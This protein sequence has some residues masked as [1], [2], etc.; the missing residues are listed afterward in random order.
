[1]D[2]K[3]VDLKLKELK[4]IEEQLEKVKYCNDFI[5]LNYVNN[6]MQK[7]IRVIQRVYQ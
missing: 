2:I 1:M 7:K 5:C 4:G 6:L 3:N